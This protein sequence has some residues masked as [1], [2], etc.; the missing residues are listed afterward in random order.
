MEVLNAKI[1]EFKL[2]IRTRVIE[3]IEAHPTLRN[4]W[5]YVK[6]ES[7]SAVW[8]KAK[9]RLITA[10]KGLV[11]AGFVGK[12]AWLEAASQKHSSHKLIRA[13]IHTKINTFNNISERPCESINIATN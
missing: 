1:A 13:L 4:A 10:A 6:G 9:K 5:E 3:F 7:N 8:V 11:M 2:Y 12:Y